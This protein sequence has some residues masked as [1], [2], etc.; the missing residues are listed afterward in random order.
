MNVEVELNLSY[1]SLKNVKYVSQQYA[2]AI[3]KANILGKA[4]P[5]G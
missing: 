4:M 1:N 2:F 5:S 3:L